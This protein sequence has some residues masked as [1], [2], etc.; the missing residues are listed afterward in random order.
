MK[1]LSA[2][3]LIPNI[4]RAISSIVI[5]ISL[6]LFASLIFNTVL[7]FNDVSLAQFFTDPTWAPLFAAPQYGIYSLI[8]GTTLVSG[9][10]I[11]I[12]LPIGLITAIFLSEYAPPFFAKILKPILE[13]LAGIPTIVY[14]FFALT[15]I[16]PLLQSWFPDQIE[17]YNALSASIAMGFMIVPMISTLSQDAFN[18]VPNQIRVGG[19]ALGL[20]KWEVIKGILIPGAKSGIIAA[21]ILGISRAIGE[22]MIVAIAAGIRPSSSWNPF[23]AVLT[24]TGYIANVAQSDVDQ[25]STAYYALYAV[26]LILFTI[27]LTLNYIGRRIITR[28]VRK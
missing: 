17:F 12:A 8:V 23:Q 18:A 26:G 15:V 27:T 3:A 21:L 28:K 1:K 16:T 4:L 24:L 5:L 10:A 11:L 14:G 6:G 20:T 7:F 19:Y 13:V 25:G 9:M 22:T 2:T